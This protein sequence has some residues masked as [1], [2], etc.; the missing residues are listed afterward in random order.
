MFDNELTVGE[1]GFNEI[2]LALKSYRTQSQNSYSNIDV[3]KLRQISR[4]S[5]GTDQQKSISSDYSAG[6][7]SPYSSTISLNSMDSASVRSLHAPVAPIRKKRLA[8]RPPSEIISNG[9]SQTNVQSTSINNNNNNTTMSRN[10]LYVSSPNLTQSSETKDSNF[11][12]Y[13]NNNRSTFL[14]LDAHNFRIENIDELYDTGQQQHSIAN[15]HH[16][17]NSNCNEHAIQNN[18]SQ[19]NGNNCQADRTSLE[20]NHRVL[21][22]FKIPAEP[23]VPRKRNIIGI[24]FKTLLFFLNL[25]F[26]FIK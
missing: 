13:N 5:D 24:H 21:H 20:Q 18:H 12:E 16:N 19:E 9:N 1:V 10:K 3:V 14:R 4:I 6:T 23:P 22:E 26:Y 8:P 7:Q 2:R 17:N 15:N 25:I 11:K